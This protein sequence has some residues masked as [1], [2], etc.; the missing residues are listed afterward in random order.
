MTRP[1]GLDPEVLA[2]LRFRDASQRDRTRSALTDC[3]D[4]GDHVKLHDCN[5][6]PCSAPGCECQEFI[7]GGGP[8]WSPPVIA[9]R[10]PCSNC[11]AL[12]DITPEAIETHAKL[13]AELVRNGERPLAKRIPC[14]KCKALEHEARIAARQ[15]HEQRE[16]PLDGPTKAA[17]ELE[18]RTN[19]NRGRHP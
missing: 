13:S 12:V 19:S 16:M 2:D 1:P 9:E 18:Q 7:R 8:R 15:P 4:C 17:R 6:G 3:D 11:G 10:W 14:S 5:V